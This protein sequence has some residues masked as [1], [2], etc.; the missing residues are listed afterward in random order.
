MKCTASYPGNF[1]AS[2][3]G[4]NGENL[5]FNYHIGYCGDYCE[6]GFVADSVT[7]LCIPCDTT[8]NS[9]EQGLNYSSCY[10]CNDNL[11]FAELGISGI[12]GKPLGECLP[13]CPLIGYYFN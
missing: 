13:S 3:D 5:S 4:E 12:N 8:C 7:W 9:C 2:V 6:S 11:Y 10:D 1:L